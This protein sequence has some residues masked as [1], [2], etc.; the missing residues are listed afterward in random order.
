LLAITHAT[1]AI[2]TIPQQTATPTATH[3]VAGSAFFVIKG[4]HIMGSTPAHAH[5]V[6]QFIHERTKIVQILFPAAH[7]G[8]T[9]TAHGTTTRTRLSTN[10]I[11]TLPILS[12]DIIL[13]TPS[14][15]GNID[16]TGTAIIFALRIFSG[17]IF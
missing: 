8:I 11:D 4:V 12:V 2:D 15:A 16:T 9:H 6:F 3:A 13:H 14:I 1:T 7:H 17:T 5:I 10:P